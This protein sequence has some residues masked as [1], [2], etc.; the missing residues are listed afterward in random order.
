M[1]GIKSMTDQ[2]KYV[3]FLRW[4]TINVNRWKT[5]QVGS[6]CTRS[7]Y[8]PCS[9]LRMPVLCKLFSWGKKSC[10][11]CINGLWSDQ[12]VKNRLCTQGGSPSLNREGKVS[13]KCTLPPP[14][15]A[16]SV[17]SLLNG[18]FDIF[19]TVCHHLILG[20]KNQARC[21]YRSL[22]CGELGWTS[23]MS[24]PSYGSYS[25]QFLSSVHPTLWQELVHETDH[26]LDSTLGCTVLIGYW[27]K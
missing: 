9:L 22:T 21:A 4:M 24:A 12:S 1:S 15:H 18:I 25:V 16:M 8:K 13:A 10:N 2:R 23:R 20:K 11:S 14:L 27:S 26:T 5:Q 3:P 6:R 17:A 19:F 7:Y